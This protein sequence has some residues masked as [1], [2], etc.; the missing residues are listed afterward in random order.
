MEEEN[1]Y[2]CAELGKATDEAR[3]S[4]YSTTGINYF[5]VNPKVNAEVGKNGMV[6]R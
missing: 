2:Q 4:T 3:K 6:F 1:A 5:T